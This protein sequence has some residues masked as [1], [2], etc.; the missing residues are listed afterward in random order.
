ML[1]ARGRDRKKGEMFGTLGCL[2]EFAGVEQAEHES[3]SNSY[4]YIWSKPNKSYFAKFSENG[5]KLMNINELY[6][7]ASNIVN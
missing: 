7:I 3:R 2:S 5:F 1:G 6:R 4:A